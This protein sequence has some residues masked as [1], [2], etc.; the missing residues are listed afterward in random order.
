MTNYSILRSPDY[1]LRTLRILATLLLLS[2]PV[3]GD[4][5]DQTCDIFVGTNST[6]TLNGN[7]TA[8]C[9]KVEG[10]LNIGGRLTLTGPDSST[11]EGSVN[12][13]G[14]TSALAFTTWS[15]TVAG[16]G[17]IV[18]KHDDAE[19]CIASGITFSTNMT[20]ISGALT[21]KGAGSFTNA[22]V[23]NAN[24]TCGT[25]KLAIGGTLADGSNAD[26][27]KVSANGAVLRFDSTLGIIATLDGNFVMSIGDYD[28]KL[29]F[30][31]PLETNGRLQ[32]S[33]GMTGVVEV[34]QNVGIDKDWATSADDLDMQGGTIQ[35]APGATFI[36]H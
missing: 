21:I 30:D 6:V 14:A 3:A 16:S 29:V 13:T 10:T 9:I 23:I 33:P 11:V 7:F 31:H 15:Q 18:G 20:T 25:L 1:R 28:S 17:Q 12:L 22:G 32:L 5:R 34:N 36:H 2:A 24:A 19:I 4:T 26:R 27:W 35:V 8:D